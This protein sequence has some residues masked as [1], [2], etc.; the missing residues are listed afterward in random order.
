MHL[1]D[2]KNTD[3]PRDSMEIKAEETLYEVNDPEIDFPDKLPDGD[4]VE[5]RRARQK[6]TEGTRIHLMNC[7]AMQSLVSCGDRGFLD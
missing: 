3:F 1:L 5:L 6:G 2:L 4:G 7:S